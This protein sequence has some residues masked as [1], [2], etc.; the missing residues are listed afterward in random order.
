MKKSSFLKLTT[1]LPG[2]VL[3]NPKGFTLIELLAVIIIL[4]VVSII[5][6]PI[7][8]DVVEDSKES[9]NKSTAYNLLDAANLY[10]TESL[11]D[12]NKANKINSLGNIYDEI[13]VSGKK[14]SNGDLRV[15]DKGN[16]AL[17][18]I[19]DNKCYKKT[20]M[21]ELEIT[22]DKEC[23]LGYVGNDETAP[24]VSLTSDVVLTNGWAK[25]NFWVNVS[26]TDEES[27]VNNYEW[28]VEST[29]CDPKNG[30]KVINHTGGIEVTVERENHVCGPC[31]EMCVILLHLFF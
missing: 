6:T 14:P 7:V 18:I 15:N 20:F 31:Q 4:A 23:S 1:N 11:L 17:S 24:I 10:Y 25:S 5:A 27:G 16:V 30:S 29:D 8:L 2:G 3:N 26:V 13:T 19:I 28:C 9:V 21:S 22:E 12:N